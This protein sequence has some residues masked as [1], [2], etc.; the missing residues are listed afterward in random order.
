MLPSSSEARPWQVP[1]EVQ[2][3][4]PSS[5]RARSYEPSRTGIL[6]YAI[7]KMDGVGG[8]KGWQW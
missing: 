1:L 4:N 2:I 6:A 3:K 8:R 5:Q 7:A